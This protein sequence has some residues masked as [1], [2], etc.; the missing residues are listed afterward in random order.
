MNLTCK[1][2]G[3][4]NAAT[5]FQICHNLTPELTVFREKFKVS[6]AVKPHLG[7]G[8]GHAC[9]VDNFDETNFLFLVTAHKGKED[10]VVF[11]TLK[12]VNSCQPYRFDHLIVFISEAIPYSKH[13]S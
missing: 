1:R 5:R 13:L 9:A 7:T 12:V 8:K 4:S 10:E 3:V 2:Q 11:F 6:N